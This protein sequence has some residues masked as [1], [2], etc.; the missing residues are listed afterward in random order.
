MRHIPSLKKLKEFFGQYMEHDYGDEA[1][2][3]LR[4]LRRNL[5]FWRDGEIKSRTMLRIADDIL[6]GHGLEHLMSEN[7]RAE[8]VY[9]NM[10]D[11]YN[12][13][14]LFDLNKGRMWATTWGDWVETEE[15]KG[16][17]FA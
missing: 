3:K 6:Q 13:T 7:Q 2:G 14:L 8:A 9:V 11:T 1:P 12:A 17:R 16:N 10:G 15:R 4:E 5:E